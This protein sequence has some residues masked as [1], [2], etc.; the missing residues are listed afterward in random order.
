MVL[1]AIGTDNGPLVS[2]ADVLTG[3]RHASEPGTLSPDI[4]ALEILNAAREV[5]DGFC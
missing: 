2:D 4:D 1:D 3:V 5:S